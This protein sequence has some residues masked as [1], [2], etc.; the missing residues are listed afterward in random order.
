MNSMM[1]YVRK[2][3]H[4]AV[5]PKICALA[6]LFCGFYLIA[7]SSAPK[8]PAE[9]TDKQNKAAEFA[10]S[11][12][13][14]YT[15]GMYERALE[16]FKL[17]LAYNGAVYNEPGIAQSYNSIGKVYL[18]QG[19]PDT[20][21]AY[22]QK[23]RAM[24]ADLNE[25]FILAQSINNLG[26]LALSK[27]D[28]TGALKQFEEAFTLIK[29]A[30]STTPGDRKSAGGL[31]AYQAEVVC[32]KAVILHNL[33]ACYKQFK[34]TEKAFTYLQQA[35][36]IN[37]ARKKYEEVAANYYMLASLYSEQ[38]DYEK[39][40]A[41]I[42]QALAYDIKV[43]NSLGIAKDYLALG[44]IYNKL[45]QTAEAYTYF[46]RSLFVYRSLADIYPSLVLEVEV[47]NLYAHLLKATEKLGK[48]EEAEELRQTLIGKK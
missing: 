14:Y 28:Y 6:T 33:G 45:E 9:V 43:E 27:S 48:K 42:L 46:K 35:L 5:L 31:A 1:Q 29:Q 40:K 47:K 25:P 26:E 10:Q 13:S 22:Y 23:A 17:A 7:C 20:A 8:Q 44:L 32:T 30:E 39:S 37:L 16:F 12:N 18:A 11:G 2:N 34:E 19:Y 38:G 36:T 24:V 4:A 21:A 41:H 3:L 15:Q